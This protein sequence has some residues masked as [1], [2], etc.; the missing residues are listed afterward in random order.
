MNPLIS[1]NPYNNEEIGR[2]EQDDS[3]T[4]K[5]KL[6]LSKSVQPNWSKLPITERQAYLRKIAAVLRK[7]KAQYGLLATQEMGKPISQGI[8]EVE[9]CATSLEYYAENAPLFLAN[10]IITIEQ[11]NS[12][13]ISYQPIGTVLAIMPWNF[14]F[15]QVYR[16]MGP[17][18]L[19]G[20]TM[21]LKHASN[22]TACA[23][24]IEEVVREAGLPDGVFTLLKVSSE[25]VNEVIA[26]PIINAVTFTG[27]TNAG[28]KVAATAA[29][30][31]K[32]QVLELGGSDA[33]VILKDAD[34]SIAVPT[35]VS[36]RLKNTGQSCVA[37]K[38][39]VVEAPIL[40]DFETQFVTLM[41][42]NRFGD[43]SDPSIDLGPMSRI[44]LRDELHEQVMKSVALGAKILTGGYIPEGTGAFYPPTVLT[45]VLPGMPA[46]DEE[47]FGPVASIIKA[48]DE[49]DAIRI[50]NDTQ[51]GLGGAIFSNDVERASRIAE[52][53]LQAGSIA[54]NDGVNSRPD[55]PFGGIKES[56]YGRELS[57]FGL[58]E[59]VNIKAISVKQQ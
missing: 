54:V 13:Y 33:Y 51:F 32:K 53:D 27:S 8:A 59:F 46:Y 47:L 23:I 29:Q 31:L 34:L 41:E 48:N 24:S 18:L 55:M 3:Q 21:V 25:A 49:A 45:N 52:E 36:G 7:N 16:A 26:N 2:Y 17:I 42:Q 43:P 20:N 11:N 56:G 30:N 35:C 1:I 9:K 6:N 4:I 12:H 19:S 10:E 15:W 50:A 22:V 58:L 5:E 28:R 37:A 39:F 40:A 44:D 14:P 57:R 38:R